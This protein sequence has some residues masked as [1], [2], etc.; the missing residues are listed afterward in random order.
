M[1]PDNVP[2]ELKQ[3]PRW[4][5]WEWREKDEEVPLRASNG[6]RAEVAKPSSWTTFDEAVRATRNR[7]LSGVGFV[8]V[9]GDPYIGVNLGDCR[10]PDGDIAWWATRIVRELA[11]YAEVSPTGKGVKLWLRAEPPGPRNRRGGVEM[12]ASQRFFTVTGDH[13]AG[14]PSIVAARQEAV[15]DLYRRLFESDGPDMSFLSRAKRARNGAKFARLW[16]GDIEGYDSHSE[17]DLALCRM[18]AWWIG[19]DPAWIEAAFSESGL[20]RR[21]KGRRL[22]YVQTTIDK[23]VESTYTRLTRLARSPSIDTNLSR[24]RSVDHVDLE[25]TGPLATSPREGRPSVVGQGGG[26]GESDAGMKAASPDRPPRKRKKPAG[27]NGRATGTADVNADGGT[28]SIPPCPCPHT[29]P[30]HTPTQANGRRSADPAPATPIPPAAAAPPSPEELAIALA[31]D[32]DKTRPD[33]GLAAF[34]LARRLRTVSDGAAEQFGDIVRAYAERRDLDPDE[35]WILFDHRWDAVRTAEGEDSLTIAMALAD[36]EP[37]RP[38]PCPYPSYARVASVA[39]H[40]ARLRG[41]EP[42][43]LPQKRLAKWLGLSQP[44]VSA[45]IGKMQRAGLIELVAEG[46]YSRGEAA[47]YRFQESPRDDPPATAADR[48]LEPLDHLPRA[49]VVGGDSP[50]VVGRVDGNE[51]VAAAPPHVGTGGKGD[52][53]RRFAGDPRQGILSQPRFIC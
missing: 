34:Q 47:E 42:I 39:Y 18:L 26:D 50:V 14:T 49:G 45:I 8:F 46:R 21:G 20:A 37:Y 3:C 7:G 9:E 31:E 10:S 12:Y 44:A 19:P 40:L 22:D 17:A 48:G 2:D 36:A 16:N 52:R 33:N 13:L 38:D 30:A 51:Y 29:R 6:R 32:H 1:N 4:M 35:F 25:N 53:L 11:S 5:C 28:T 41:D 43:F 15:D 24:S 23:A 27:P